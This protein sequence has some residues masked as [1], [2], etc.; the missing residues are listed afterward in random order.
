MKRFTIAI[1][2]FIASCGGSNN[3]V[4]NNSQTPS[5][6]LSLADPL[7]ETSTINRD[8]HSAILAEIFKV[9]TGRAFA[10]RLKSIPI[11]TDQF[12]FSNLSDDGT[13]EQS[14]DNGGTATTR[15]IDDIRSFSTQFVYHNC[16]SSQVLLNGDYEYSEDD[17]GT[18]RSSN[19]LSAEFDGG[20]VIEFSGF[21]DF[22]CCLSSISYTSS[23]QL[24]YNFAS[25]A[26]R[27]R[28]TNATTYFSDGESFLTDTRIA[29][30]TGEFSIETPVSGSRPLD[31]VIETDFF[32]ESDSGL[33]FEEAELLASN[34]TFS[35]GRMSVTAQD[36]SRLTLDA[37][38]GAADTASITIENVDGS[39]SF[40][41]PW[42]LWSGILNGV[43]Q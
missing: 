5:D 28:I 37:E 8:N 19:G 11:Q 26:E 31:V 41:Q 43:G 20:A 29:T 24:N 4:S 39:E 21:A 22:S 15:T 38:S 33:T 34:W 10:D 17:E 27:F 25:A 32:F 36:G 6:E 16:H 9:Y 12:G 2:V 13:N 40:D 42:S 7:S 3:N 35:T 23:D 18:Q 1:A 14:C 30:M